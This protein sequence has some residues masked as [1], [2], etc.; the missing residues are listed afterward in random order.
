MEG[1]D[2]NILKLC[3]ICIQDQKRKIHGKAA[4]KP[5]AKKITSYHII[6]IKYYYCGILSDLLIYMTAKKVIATN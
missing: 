6:I 1:G 4:S 2:C 3:D 5:D